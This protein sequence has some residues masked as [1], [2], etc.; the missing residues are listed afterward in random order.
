MSRISYLEKKASSQTCP[1]CQE[2]N[3]AY[4]ISVEANDAV[5][6]VNRIENNALKCDCCESVFWEQ[7]KVVG[8]LSANDAENDIYLRHYC[9]I[10]AGFDLG[11]QILSRLK[12]G[13]GSS[14]LEVGCGF[15]YNVHFWSKYLKRS[16]VGL[17]LA[18]YGSKGQEIF[19]IDIRK[20]YL[21]ETESPYGKFDIVLSTEVIE[22]VK[23]PRKFIRALKKNL[24]DHG[25]LILT[26]P[27]ADFLVDG[28]D[29]SLS[30]AVLSPGFHEFVLSQKAFELVLQEEGFS[31][32]VVERHHER[33]IAFAVLNG[34]V[35]NLVGD[36]VSRDSYIDYL[37]F[38]VEGA[39][40]IA[41]EGALYRLFKELING[42]QWQEAEI[43]LGRIISEIDERYKIK[44]SGLFYADYQEYKNFTAQDFIYKVPP[45]LGPLCYYMGILFSRD[46]RYLHRKLNLFA[47]AC[48]LM[49]AS[50]ATAPELAQESE[51]LIGTARLHHRLALLDVLRNTDAQAI[52]SASNQD[53]S[54]ATEKDI[55]R[56]VQHKIDC[57]FD[58]KTR[59]SPIYVRWCRF[60]EER[61]KGDR[62]R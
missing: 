6:G 45:Y 33:L 25:V 62:R 41:R 32:V 4:F 7:D 31:D 22:H 3:A 39:T 51:S 2:A 19:D 14:L 9:L 21:T 11:V 5:T 55:A 53:G 1:I 48:S 12:L 28:V 13:D 16:A 38:I 27:A 10:G 61:L 60:L 17:E 56:Y 20:I 57:G 54:F 47:L 24:D 52:G 49:E 59:A 23:D 30:L 8:Y 37:R 36:A 26:T 35:N 46:S 15:G 58:I 43:T 18:D 29:Q 40:G 44:M 50:I 42:G 34:S